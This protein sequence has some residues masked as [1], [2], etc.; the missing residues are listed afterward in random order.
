MAA[1]YESSV[2]DRR[3]GRRRGKRIEGRKKEGTTMGIVDKGRG[4]E[5]RSEGRREEGI[6]VGIVH[7]VCMLLSL[8]TPHLYHWVT[9]DLNSFVVPL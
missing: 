4:R 2:R 5:D 6:T 8:H 1:T 3:V 7:H 9:V